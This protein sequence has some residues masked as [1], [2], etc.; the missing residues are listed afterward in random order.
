M[1]HH[2]PFVFFPLLTCAVATIGTYLLA[3]NAFADIGVSDNQIVIGVVN[4][5]SGPVAP[6]GL[7][8]NSGANAY[9]D[10][11][12]AS[13]GVA[14]RKLKVIQYDDGY[15][16]QKTVFY[17]QKL[18][19]EDR[20]F[21][22]FDF[23]GSPTCKAAL[24]VISKENIPFLFPRSGE[25]SLRQPF[26]RM[27]FN[28]R[29]GFTEEVDAL[30]SY[31]LKRGLK[32]IGFV[33]QPDSFGDGIQ[34]AVV[35]ALGKNGA[36]D[37]LERQQSAFVGVATINRNSHDSVEAK[38]AFEKLVGVEPDVV[39]FAV[40]AATAGE[41]IRMAVAAKKKWIFMGVNSLSPVAGSVGNLGAEIVISQVTPNPE[42]GDLALAQEFRSDMTKY[43]HGAKI[44]YISF[45]GYINARVLGLGLEKVGREL[46]RERLIKTLETE[47]FL[48]GGLNLS[49][50]ADRHVNDSAQVFLT[51]AKG[52][53]LAPV[54]TLL[55]QSL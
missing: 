13:G 20:A 50:S 22:L 27:V 9:F 41:V 55:N 4:A 32:R 6:S 49:M 36:S 44:D 47:K 48:I 11:L 23:Q 43:S 19:R 21:L 10:R 16:P 30:I 15:E 33:K 3:A 38:A 12:N 35:T 25:L 54:A 1:N 14:G 7:G 24:T 45:E 51:V 31:A 5:T 28:L 18:V 40:P 42:S 29:A 2:K 26:N 46:T 37:I 39:L 8:L 17:A 53:K 52:G 34:S